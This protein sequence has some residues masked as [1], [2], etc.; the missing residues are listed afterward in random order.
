MPV[1]RPNIPARRTVR[2]RMG[3]QMGGRSRMP[4]QEERR[5]GFRQHHKRNRTKY[6]E[7]KK[8]HAGLSK[9]PRDEQDH[10]FLGASFF[11]RRVRDKREEEEE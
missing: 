3:N 5:G 11:V 4:Q 6:D 7:K 1:Y 9:L 10:F 2:V 8:Q